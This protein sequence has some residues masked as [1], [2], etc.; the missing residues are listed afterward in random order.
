M[1]QVSNWLD[2][3]QIYNSKKAY[4]DVLNR[5]NATKC[6]ILVDQLDQGF[7]LMPNCPLNPP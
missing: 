3:S 7:G 1:N 2:L 5:N 4:F 6:K